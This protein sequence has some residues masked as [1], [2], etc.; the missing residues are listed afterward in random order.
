MPELP[1]CLSPNTNNC[2]TFYIR[3]RQQAGYFHNYGNINDFI[4]K[5]DRIM[6]GEDDARKNLFKFMVGLNDDDIA[7]LGRLL[8]QMITTR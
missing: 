3:C 7:A 4:E 6:V 8:D 5:I 1:T 2:T